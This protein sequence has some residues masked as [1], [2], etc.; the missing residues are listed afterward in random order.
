MII[1]RAQQG[2]A[3][4]YAARLGRPT[5]SQFHKIITPGGKP[6][7]GKQVREYMCRLIAETL[8]NETTDD[9]LGHVEWVQRGKENEPL[10]AAA[11]QSVNDLELEDGGFVTTDDNRIGCSPD[12][13]IVG[14]N[15]ALEIKCPA[16]WTQIGYLLDGPG[17][18]YKPQVQGQLMIGE[19][20]A[21]HFYTW[22]KQCP[23]F[24]RVTVPDVQYQRVL[25]QLLSDFL[26]EFDRNLERVKARGEF[27]PT[28]RVV[29]PLEQAYPEAQAGVVLPDDREL[30][31]WL[32]R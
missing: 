28:A 5:A 16:P 27:F 25:R 23:S 3:E 8:L 2:T 15:E 29:Q 12:R 20:D 18:N 30:D 4:W 10:A 31:E 17:D 11:F 26:E 24:Y 13:L 19:W 21:V 7:T 9:Q 6:A 14:R 22:E 1:H 32:N